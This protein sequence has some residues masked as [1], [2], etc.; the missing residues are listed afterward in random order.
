M[1]NHRVDVIWIMSGDCIEIL[2]VIDADNID[3]SFER[4]EYYKKIYDNVNV[5]LGVKYTTDNSK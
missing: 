1:N 3:F 2:E 4:Q 5:T